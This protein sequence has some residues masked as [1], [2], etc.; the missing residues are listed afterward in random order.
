MKQITLNEVAS[1]LREHDNFKIL[2]HSYPAALL[3]PLT[4]AFAA[5]MPSKALTYTVQ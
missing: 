3:S 1:L 4:A 2:T 5:S